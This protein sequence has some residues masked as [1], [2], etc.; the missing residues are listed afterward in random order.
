MAQVRLQEDERMLWERQPWETAADFRSFKFYLEQ[1]PPRSV[2]EAYR[3]W[4]RKKGI[5]TASNVRAPNMW[6]QRA[7]IY[8]KHGV[9]IPNAYTWKQRAEAR[10]DHLTS[11]ANAAVEAQWIKEAMGATE[12]LGRLAQQGRINIAEFFTVRDVPFRDGEGEIVRDADGNP[13]TQQVN[14]INWE[15]VNRYGHLVKSITP[16][17]YGPKLELHDGQAAL[18]HTGKA[19]KLFTDNIDLTSAGKPLQNTENLTDEQFRSSLSQLAKISL[20]IAGGDG[21]QPTAGSTE[22]DDPKG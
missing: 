8:D 7:H 3:A 13:M 20:A 21:V 19:L 15:M 2:D 11:I 1:E 18:V 6:R 17:R 9:K 14:E 16:T 5:E 10:D 22:S 4:R 12:V